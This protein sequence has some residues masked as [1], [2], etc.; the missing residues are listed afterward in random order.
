MELAT[1]NAG[2]FDEIKPRPKAMNLH[3]LPVNAFDVGLLTVLIVGILTGRKHGMSEELL[4]LV[5]WLT[6]VVACGYLYGPI[7][8][9]LVGVTYFSL[10]SCYI[11]AYTGVA[12]VTLGLF[13]LLKHNIGGK[14]IGSDIFGKS[15]YYLG[16]G[17][18][19]VRFGCVVIAGLALLNA[20]YFTPKEVDAMIRFQNDMYGSNFFPGLHTAQ[21]VVFEQSLS[22]P[23]I[24]R[25][26]SFLLITP[27]LPQDTALHQREADWTR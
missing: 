10:L 13:A 11:I 4:S 26:L 18:G 9:Q 27:T 15:E 22:G 3:N 19:L 16:M 17:S 8:T 6:V 21:E 23:W 25:N 14:L 2:C 5:K 1:M 24:K 12:A 7:G 20:R